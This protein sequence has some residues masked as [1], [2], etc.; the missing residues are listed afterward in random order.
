M[1]KR[2]AKGWKKHLDFM[3]LDVISLHIALII[4]Y[5]VRHGLHSFVYRSESY[6]TLGLWMTV[7]SFLAAVLFSTMHNV[8]R[9]GY[10][11]EMVQTLIHSLL[12][13]GFSAI[14]LFTMKDG[15]AISRVTL[16]VHLVIYLVL[17]YSTRMI[18]KRFLRKYVAG[19]VE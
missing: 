12:V 4:A 6:R 5:M 10:A 19:M 8:L 13:F 1:Y 14:F 17:S 11:K 16:W 7:F 15:E 2:R 9:R 18:Y 3:I